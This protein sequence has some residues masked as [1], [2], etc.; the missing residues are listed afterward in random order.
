M[1]SKNLSIV[2]RTAA[3]LAAALQDI[4][5]LEDCDL[6]IAAGSA[7]DLCHPYGSPPPALKLTVKAALA[8]E[9]TAASALAESLV[10]GDCPDAEAVCARLRAHG[11]GSVVGVGSPGREIAVAAVAEASQ[12]E[13]LDHGENLPLTAARIHAAIVVQDASDKLWGHYDLRLAGVEGGEVAVSAVLSR[14]ETER[15]RDRWTSPSPGGLA[16]WV[17]DQ[18]EAGFGLVSAWCTVAGVPQGVVRGRIRDVRAMSA[19]S[20]DCAVQAAA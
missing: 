2:A 20:A 9:L 17:A 14:M 19:Q 7:V 16:E 18:D 15:R 3:T 10:D 6:S 13:A 1:R 11:I 5:S 4:R 12:T 8:A